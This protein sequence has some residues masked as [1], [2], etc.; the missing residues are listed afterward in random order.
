MY[1]NS[2]EFMLNDTNLCMDH[3]AVWQCS[4]K[5]QYERQCSQCVPVCTVVV[6]TAVCSSALGGVWQCARQ[7]AAVHACSSVQ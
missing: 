7:C 1:L 4:S 3:A 6:R 5:L 2:C